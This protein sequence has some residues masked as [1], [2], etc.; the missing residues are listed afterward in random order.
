MPGMRFSMPPMKMPTL[1]NAN[2][3][4]KKNE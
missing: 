1:S 3:N 4:M 2:M